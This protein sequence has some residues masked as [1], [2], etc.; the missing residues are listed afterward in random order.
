MV[1]SND[2]YTLQPHLFQPPYYPRYEEYRNVTF[3]IDVYKNLGRNLFYV[4]V[5]S[6]CSK[7]ML[8]EL[9]H[10]DDLRKVTKY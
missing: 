4:R 3:T 7:G 6:T 2:E 9:Q 10:L 1:T 8:L 5:K